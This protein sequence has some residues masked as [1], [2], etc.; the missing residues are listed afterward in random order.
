MEGTGST[1]SKLA[2]SM[3]SP[4]PAQFRRL[5]ASPVAKMVGVKTDRAGRARI[6]PFMNVQDQQ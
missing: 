2:L 5:S 1:T 4:T 6:G 3:T